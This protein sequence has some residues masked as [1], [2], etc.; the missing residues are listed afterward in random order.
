[1]FII[2]GSMEF[3]P[4]KGECDREKETTTIY[5]F[6]HYF[7]SF[8]VDC[9]QWHTHHSS[10]FLIIVRSIENCFQ[11]K[12][13]KD[14]MENWPVHS[15]RSRRTEHNSCFFFGEQLKVFSSCHFRQHFIRTFVSHRFLRQQNPREKLFAC[16]E[17]IISTD[18]RLIVNSRQQFYLASHWQRPQILVRWFQISVKKYVQVSNKRNKAWKRI[19]AKKSFLM[20]RIKTQT[21]KIAIKFNFDV[22]H[23]SIQRSK[24]QHCRWLS[25]FTSAS[26][27]KWMCVFVCIC[28]NFSLNHSLLYHFYDVTLRIP[29]QL[30]TFCVDHFFV[31]VDAGHKKKW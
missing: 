31:L 28:G 16:H 4:N 19:A 21:G 8:D 9:T 13:R 1:M 2:F 27:E 30:Y 23:Q 10:R 14:S 18:L 17:V 12:W 20:I 29:R 25:C 24:P 5:L 22:L 6:T 3:M 15:E 11:W 7:S 26:Y